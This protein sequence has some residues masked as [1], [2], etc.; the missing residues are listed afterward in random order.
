MRSLSERVVQIAIVCFGEIRKSRSE[1]FLQ[2]KCA[3]CECFGIRDAS[4]REILGDGLPHQLGHRAI[5]HAR[6]RLERSRLRFRQLNLCTYHDIMITNLLTHWHH[7]PKR[8]IT[9]TA[10]PAPKART[11]R[12]AL[13]ACTATQSKRGMHSPAC[14]S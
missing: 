3:G 11:R 7:I 1:A 13:P 9:P 10:T 2:F 8:D 4:A 12:F 6:P 14:A 5:F